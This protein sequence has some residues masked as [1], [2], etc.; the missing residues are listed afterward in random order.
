[1][2][3]PVSGRLLDTL[4]IGFSYYSRFVAPWIEEALKGLAVLGLFYWNRIGF[5]L[6]AVIAGFAVGVG[7]AVI[8][9]SLF[10]FEFPRMSFGVWLVRGLGTAI[11]H[12]G[13]T[14][15]FAVVSHEMTENGARGRVHQWKL[16][17]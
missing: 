10:L 11:M 14:A 5:K 1:L 17:P 3:Y 7:F 13:A 16:Q 8:E 9:N 6:D 4:P 15:L 2:A 12:G